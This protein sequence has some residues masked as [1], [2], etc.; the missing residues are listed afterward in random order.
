MIYKKFG[1][2]FEKAGK[3]AKFALILGEDEIKNN[4]ISVK[5]LET[6]EQKKLKLKDFVEE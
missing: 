4:E 2:Q 3:I 5:N 1:K 6:G